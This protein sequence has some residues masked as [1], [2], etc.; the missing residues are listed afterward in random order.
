[1]GSGGRVGAAGPL[2]EWMGSPSYRLLV[3]PMLVAIC[4]A[5]YAAGDAVLAPSPVPKEPGFI[6]TILGSRAVVASIRLAVISAATF[7]VLSVVALIARGQWLVRVG[8][9]EAHLVDEGERGLV[10]T[11]TLAARYAD[12]VEKNTVL[13]GELAER[14]RQLKGLGQVG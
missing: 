8:P 13:I 7:V 5:A 4:A 6:D 9:F 10:S 11:D 1:M 14:D 12:A 3:V 2:T